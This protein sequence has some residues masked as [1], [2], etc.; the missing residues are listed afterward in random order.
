MMKFL[1]ENRRY[2]L[3]VTGLLLIILFA[4]TDM[5]IIRYT[6]S[7]T[8]AFDW[9]KLSSTETPFV[10]SLSGETFYQ[11]KTTEG[12]PLYFYKNIETS[13]C[14]DNKCR[15]LNLE[16]FWNITG[17]YLGFQLPEGEFLSRYEHKPFNPEDY[18]RL[19]FLLADP[20]LPIGNRPF[21]SLVGQAGGKGNAVDAVS[22]A[23][24]Q[25]VKDYVVEGAAY[26]TYTLWKILYGPIRAQI[27]DL[28]DG[29]MNPEL[30]GL[31]LKSPSSED[32]VWALERLDT[33]SSLSPVMEQRISDLIVR[34]DYFSAYA[35]LNAIQPR[36]LQTKS[37]QL[38]LLDQY[39]AVDYGLKK[40]LIET[41]K[42]APALAPEVIKKSNELLPA[43]NG[44]QLGAMLELYRHHQ[45]QDEASGRA[46][47]R[48]LESDDRFKTQKIYQFLIELSLDDST[49][50][51]ALAQY[52][53][54]E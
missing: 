25:G 51:E 37:F 12:I 41:L 35:A 26:T 7:A 54:G 10:D 23:T 2:G 4:A 52:E 33:S 39:P 43:L 34:S 28:T 24:A 48:L 49:I 30:L 11:V 46:L 47:A 50:K 31:I 5:A 1:G 21:E 20:I 27:V 22:G 36:Y 38:R 17:R 45:V 18:E 29:E 9:N 19:N 32:I 13:V 8:I 16:V 44:P 14:Y 42:T 6:Q 53:S 15:P 40:L 3:L